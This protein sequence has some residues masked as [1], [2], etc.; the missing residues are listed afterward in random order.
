MKIAVRGTGSVGRTLAGRLADVG[1]D[2]VIGTRDVEQTLARTAPDAW[3][4]EPYSTWQQ[5]D[6]ESGSPMTRGEPINNKQ[7]GGQSA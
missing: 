1:H 2:V 7:Y 5:D 6:D 4:T 3:G